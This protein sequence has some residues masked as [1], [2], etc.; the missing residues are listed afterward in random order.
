M[1]KVPVNLATSKGTGILH[2]QAII[3]NGVVYCSGQV[4]ADMT[5]GEIVPG[6][7]QKHT[8]R[9]ITPFMKNVIL[10]CRNSTNVFKT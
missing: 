2:N 9:L 10:R 4:P 1:S 7:I 3:A 5:T 8:V 6:D